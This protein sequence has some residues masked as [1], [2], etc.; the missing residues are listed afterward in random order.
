M[1]ASSS[2]SEKA[3]VKA[4][5]KKVIRAKNPKK[6]YASLK[7]SQ[8]ALLKRNIRNSKRKLRVTKSKHY[9]KT[10]PGLGGTAIYV[11]RVMDCWFSGSLGWHSGSKQTATKNVSWE[12]RGVYRQEAAWGA[13]GWDLFRGTECPQLRLNADLKQQ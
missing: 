4:I 13:G 1:A 11:K 7:K 3:T 2:K 6:I 8:K 12:G 5:T 9:L 10:M